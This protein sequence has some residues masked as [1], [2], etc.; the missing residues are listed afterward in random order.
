[1]PYVEFTPNKDISASHSF[2]KLIL[3]E[4]VGY[5][6]HDSWVGNIPGDIKFL[7]DRIRDYNIAIDANGKKILFMRTMG[8]GDILFLS[9]LI[10]YIKITYP[11]CE[12]AFTCIEEQSDLANMIKGVDKVLPMPL[13][14]K[15]FEEFDYHFEVSN[16][17]EGNEE[18]IS[19]NAYDVYFEKLGVTMS[20]DGTAMINND[21][22]RPAIKDRY[23]DLSEADPSII[24]IHPFANDP[25]RQFEPMAVNA[26]CVELI[27]AGY[28]VKVFSSAEEYEVNHTF[29]DERIKWTKGLSFIDT[30]KHLGTC[31]TLIGCDSLMIHLAQAMFIKTIAIY[32]PFDSNTRVKYYKDIKVIDTNPDCRCQLHGRGQC[33]KGFK[34][35]PCLNVDPKLIIELIEDKRTDFEYKGSISYE[36]T[37]FNIGVVDAQL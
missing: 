29:F 33:P 14:V 5:V 6:F 36:Y 2:G 26:L 19:R 16:L 37:P 35:S 25:I 11:T 28:L 23:L 24:G 32:G 21:Y 20:S 9:A 8:G 10:D 17:L 13:T 1:M 3:K 31:S 15:D 22:K 30:V 34:S 7:D 12:I 4:N 18:N 27:E